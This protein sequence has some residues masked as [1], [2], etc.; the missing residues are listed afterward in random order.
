MK[1]DLSEHLAFL[2]TVFLDLHFDNPIVITN[3]NAKDYFIRLMKWSMYEK[4]RFDGYNYLEQLIYLSITSEMKF[5]SANKLLEDINTAKKE[6]YKEV[7]S[8]AEKAIKLHFQNDLH[9]IPD[10]VSKLI[11]YI[12][13]PTRDKYAY[14]D[15]RWFMGIDVIYQ[16]LTEDEVKDIREDVFRESVE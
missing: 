8:E 15:D 10:Y 7:L 1:A 14:V 6:E 12:N 2:K 3:K 9:L 5:I 16:Y 13:K 11:K 4:F